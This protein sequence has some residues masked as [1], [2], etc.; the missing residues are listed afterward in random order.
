[1]NNS[2]ILKIGAGIL[3]LQ[4][5]LLI[6]I[7]Q[8]AFSPFYFYIDLAGFAVL[9]AGFFLLSQE[10][11][12]HKTNYLVGAI[13][14]FGWLISR[15]M[16]QFVVA[17]DFMNDAGDLGDNLD[18]FD[19][20]AETIIDM[21]T[22]FLISAICLVVAGFFIMKTKRSGSTMF[23]SYTLVNVLASYLMAS[24]FIGA[25][26][27]EAEEA[28]GGLIFGVLIKFLVVPI[29]GIVAF[30]QMVFKDEEGPVGVIAK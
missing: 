2:T 4:N 9:G 7:L 27:S 16:W 20:L 5:V 23:F 17:G 1:M 11:E 22:W 28:V 8:G 30:A 25:T 19:A 24:P 12:L 21:A 10:D 18:D 15:I 6:L 29:L 13:G 14:I 3:L 26:V